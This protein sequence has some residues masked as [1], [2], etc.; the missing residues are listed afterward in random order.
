MGEEEKPKWLEKFF[1][2]FQ[3]KDF[4][5]YTTGW[6]GCGGEKSFRALFLYF[7][8]IL[9]EIKEDTITPLTFLSDKL[10]YATFPEEFMSHGYIY[11]KQE[12]IFVLLEVS[13]DFERRVYNAFRFPRIKNIE[14]YF[15]GDTMFYVSNDE[16]TY[17]LTQKEINI[18]YKKYKDDIFFYKNN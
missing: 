7:K 10:Q 17:W 5:E 4:V 1:N 13:T 15:D 12:Q 9:F 8:Q 6:R 16:K 14:D 3:S 2:N 11:C 18:L